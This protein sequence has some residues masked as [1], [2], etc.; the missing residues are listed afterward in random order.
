MQ[1]T[2]APT[3]IVAV[4]PA[5]DDTLRAPFPTDSAASIGGVSAIGV[6]LLGV[7][8]PGG[9]DSASQGFVVK[10]DL[11]KFPATKAGSASP[12]VVHLVRRSGQHIAKTDTTDVTGASRKLIVNSFFLADQDLLAG[13]K[14]D[15]AVVEVSTSYKGVP[16]SGSPVRFAVPIKVTLVLK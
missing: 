12:A 11:K 15:S 8:V 5:G 10:Y 14:V 2:F 3:T 7:P 1:V 4:P 6:L 16:V 13:T 9:S